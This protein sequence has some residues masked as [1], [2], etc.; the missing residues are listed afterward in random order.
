MIHENLIVDKLRVLDL[1][2]YGM[3]GGV[4]YFGEDFMNIAMQES[5]L[6]AEILFG[7]G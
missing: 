3:D 1:E 2:G 5:E 7:K 6:G 4:V